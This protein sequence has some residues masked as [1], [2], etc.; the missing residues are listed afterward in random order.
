M[1]AIGKRHHPTVIFNNKE[2][3]LIDVYAVSELNTGEQEWK[4]FICHRSAVSTTQN[5]PA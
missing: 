3:Q 2:L 5:L 4:A 1:A